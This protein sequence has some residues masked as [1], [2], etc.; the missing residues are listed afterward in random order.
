MAIF[1]NGTTFVPTAQN[2]LIMV[3]QYF[4]QIVRQFKRHKNSFL[5]NLAGLTS[6]L[7]CVILI[8]LWVN[9]ELQIDRFHTK[10]IYQIL[11]NEQLNGSLNTVEGTPGI[12]ADALIKDFPEVSLAV[13]T[14]PDYWL[15]RSKVGDGKNTKVSAA[16]KFA[17]KDFF[18]VFSYP[19]I[20]GDSRKV[21]SAPGNIVVSASLA[22]K[23]FKTTDVIG[24]DLVW[25]NVE[26][27]SAYQG[28]IAGVF[29][30]I[31]AQSSEHFDFL[32]SSDILLY[33]HDSTYSKWQNYGP[34][35]YVVLN[36]ETDLPNFNKKIEHLLNTKGVDNY[37]LFARPFSDAYLYNKIENGRITG[38]RIDYVWLF[39]LSA[40]LIL[41]IACINF[42]NL[43]TASAA[44]NLKEIGIKKALG[45]SRSQLILQ[46]LTQSVM[47]SFIS[48][49]I[50]LFIVYLTLPSFSN[51]TGKRLT[52]TF[53]IQFIILALVTGIAAGLYPA[54][55][56]SKL[57]PIAALKGKLLFSPATIW[58]RQGLVIFQFATS[59]ILIVGVLVVLRQVR[60]V[61]T[62]NQGFQKEN[63]L[64]FEIE[65][66]LK[67]NPQ[68]AINA[69]RQLPGV[70]NAAAIDREFL[71]DLS[72]TTGS[73]DWEDR[74]PAEVIRFQ[75]AD[76][77]A[78][79]IETLGMEMKAGRPFSEAYGTDTNNIIINEAGIKAMR[80]K[81]PIGKTFTLW[82]NKM[83]IIGIVKDFHFE[84]M[85]KKIGP[86]FIRYKPA[87]ATRIVVR[88]QPGQ[89]AN[90][91]NE[92]K[93]YHHTINPGYTLEFKF[94]DL[95]FQQQYLTETR[96][97]MLSRYFAMLAII[98]SCL[99][100]YG[101]AVFAV[102]KRIKEVGIRKV[103]GATTIHLM[104]LL[105]LD[106]VKLVLIAVLISL[107]IAYLCCTNW[108]SSF[109]YRI[110]LQWWLFAVGGCVAIL[111]SIIT[112]FYQTYKAATTNPVTSLKVE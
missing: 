8:Y 34:L 66:T 95:D 19:L 27:Q 75:R 91:I 111:I 81:K 71:G 68:L 94:L 67:N 11:Q 92:I 109:A 88:V 73:F 2:Q 26:L 96:M 58:L 110:E 69:I 7:T 12:L 59:G 89:L 78:G 100:L 70:L 80:L 32:V 105:S 14:S 21:L 17:S 33:A 41:L 20:Y 85:H 46:Y 63:V 36:N 104:C 5:I 10:K 1:L 43:T 82:G 86:M 47:L 22:K 65:G 97:A 107:P 6:G 106:F 4:L 60:Y 31:P 39:A 112:I 61:Q 25:S 54:I 50:S 42:T 15:N 55:Y 18:N 30:D 87:N 52:L 45:V 57:R 76:V 53:D 40:I 79:F 98:I 62:Q 108:L 13:T 3:R 56:L 64:Y 48:L 37:T 102:E 23:L 51:I 28:Q 29:Q 35:T 83:Q 77:T 101:L 93:E 84:S 24:R 16:G 44:N 9:S 99:G 90:V 49:I 72:F 74:N 38:G 103:L